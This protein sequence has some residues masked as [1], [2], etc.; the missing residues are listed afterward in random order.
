MD[1]GGIT[2]VTIARKDLTIG[3]S[4]EARSVDR[5]T[6]SAAVPLARGSAELERSVPSRHVRYRLERYRAGRC[7]DW[8][9]A[10]ADAIAAAIAEELDRPVDYRPVTPDG[11]ARA[12]ELIAP[13]L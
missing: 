12:A 2:P 11:A 10:D 8:E 6:P 5:P 3:R 7:M 9:T 4:P 13:L 1:R